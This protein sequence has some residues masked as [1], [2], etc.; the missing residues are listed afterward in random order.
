MTE[1]ERLKYRLFEEPNGL[2]VSNISI[3]PG[4]ELVDA[5]KMAEQLNLVLDQLMAGDY[6]I[7]EDYDE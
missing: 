2:L 1:V 6:E 3:F 4:T 5:E 7:I